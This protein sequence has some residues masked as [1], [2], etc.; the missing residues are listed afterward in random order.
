MSA[1][2][3]MNCRT[4]KVY[5]FLGDNKGSPYTERSWIGFQ[6]HLRNQ[7]EP[8][9]H[10]CVIEVSFSNA[11]DFDYQW[12]DHTPDYDPHG[13][14]EPTRC[15]CGAANG[16]YH[17]EHCRDLF[18]GQASSNS[19]SAITVSV[20]SRFAPNAVWLFAREQQIT[21]RRCG[22]WVSLHPKTPTREWESQA[23][24]FVTTHAACEKQHEP[25]VMSE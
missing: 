15:E 21:C 17:F 2:Y 12:L 8:G 5:F 25:L 22:M 6:K 13:D 14:I 20:L 16:E 4:H 3:Y 1:D 19:P 23:T 9:R 7:A 10:G 11:L 18:K 24:E